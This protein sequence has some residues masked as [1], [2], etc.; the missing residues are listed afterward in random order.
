M[1]KK[2]LKTSLIAA[3]L[4]GC[5]LNAAQAQWNLTGN[6]NA[7]ATSILGTTNAFG[8]NLTTNNVNRMTITSAGRIGV[9]L[10]TPV[11][12]FSIKGSGGTPA[13]RILAPAAS[14]S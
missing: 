13:A 10:T 11:N 6:A 14:W 12:I 8:L 9:G 4:A 1:K 7:T 3:V 2:L 5:T